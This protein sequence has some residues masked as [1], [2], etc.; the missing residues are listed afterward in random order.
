AK[1]DGQF[2]IVYT[3]PDLIKP[4]PFPKGYQ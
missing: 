3:S 4:D 1:P 2:E